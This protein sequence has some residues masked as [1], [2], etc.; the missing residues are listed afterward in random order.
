MGP[1]YIRGW[2]GKAHGGGVVGGK[3]LNKEAR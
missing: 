1:V 2:V 3:D